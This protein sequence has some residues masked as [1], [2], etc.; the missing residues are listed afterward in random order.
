MMKIGN[1]TKNEYN[2]KSSIILQIS[3]EKGKGSAWI[4]THKDTKGMKRLLK[5]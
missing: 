1:L 2:K 4:E 3:E 5:L